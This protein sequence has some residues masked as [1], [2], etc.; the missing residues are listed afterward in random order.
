MITEVGAPAA[1]IEPPVLAALQERDWGYYGKNTRGLR[2]NQVEDTRT[3]LRNNHSLMTI[4][5]FLSEKA[6]ESIKSPAGTP[7]PEE[8]FP[9][10]PLVLPDT[11]ES[12]K[13]DVPSFY[14]P[15]EIKYS[16]F[17]IDDFDF[18]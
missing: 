5:K 1:K 8:T 17:G 9:E 13:V 16:R 14:Q 6:R 2:R 15:V 10:Y 12:H 4:P 7:A 11:I 18:A 3:M